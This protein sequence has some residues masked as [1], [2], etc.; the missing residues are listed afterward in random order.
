MVCSRCIKVVKQI[1]EKHQLTMQSIELGKVLIEEEVSPSQLSEV[2]KDLQEEGFDIVDDQRAMLVQSIK[3]L[4]I[5]KIHHGDLD[6]MKENFSDY[7]SA[8]LHRDY[9]YLSTLFSSMENT[10][11]EQFAILQK[12][13]KIKELLVYDEMPINDIAF[14]LGYSSQPIWQPS[15]RKIPVSLQASSKSLKIIIA[16]LWTK[17]NIGTRM[18]AN[19]GTRMGANLDANGHEFQIIRVTIAAL[20]Q[21]EFQ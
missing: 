12:I 4:V 19:F 9:N 11:I 2:R 5:D 1:I 17:F 13:E 16:I 20:Q 15:S 18:G 6:E 7:L 21:S 10:T 8:Q 14:R 3:D